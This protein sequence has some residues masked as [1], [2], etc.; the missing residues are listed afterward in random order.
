MAKI[1]KLILQVLTLS[2]VISTVSLLI[3]YVCAEG[4]L[5]ENIFGAV[6]FYGS[7]L[8]INLFVLHIIVFLISIVVRNK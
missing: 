7:I 2:F 8:T 3:G 4:S 1:Q 6:G 5:I